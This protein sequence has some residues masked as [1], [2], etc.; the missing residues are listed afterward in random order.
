MK[1][2]CW[3]VPLFTSGHIRLRHND[4]IKFSPCI[5]VIYESFEKYIAA[6]WYSLYQN[7]QIRLEI[8]SEAFLECFEV[9]HDPFRQI[10]NICIYMDQIWQWRH[11]SWPEVEKWTA[12]H[13]FFIDYDAKRIRSISVTGFEKKIQNWPS[14]KKIST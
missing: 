3:A 9:S 5:F 2:L 11:R 7:Y 6:I 14:L 10:R 4:V 12:Q 1:D 13:K 8:N